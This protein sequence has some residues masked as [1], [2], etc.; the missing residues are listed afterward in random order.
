MFY[1][2]SPEG[3]ILHVRAQPGARKD[4]I[5]GEWGGRATPAHSLKIRITAPPEKGRANEAIIRLLAKKLGLKKSAISV[6]Y[7]E[8]SR[9]KKILIKGI[10][11]LELKALLET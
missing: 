1:R 6:V 10:T 2:E 11:H 9:D 7:G 8:T 3:I 5:A 4:E